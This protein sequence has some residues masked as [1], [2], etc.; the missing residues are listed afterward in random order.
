MFFF[1]ACFAVMREHV[2]CGHAHPSLVSSMIRRVE[3]DS[4]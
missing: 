4:K 1:T 3:K 2:R